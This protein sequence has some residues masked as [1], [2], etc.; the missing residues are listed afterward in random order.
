MYIDRRKIS[1]N[2]ELLI[3][4]CLDDEESLLQS[5]SLLQ[6]ELR[7]ELSSVTNRQRRLEFL[8]EHI[9]LKE[10]LGKEKRLLHEDSG[11]PYLDD[12]R[13]KISVSHSSHGEVVVAL[14]IGVA[15][16]LGIDIERKRAT[17]VRVMHKFL[18]EKEQRQIEQI[19]AERRLDALALYWCAKETIFKVMPKPLPNFADEMLVEPFEICAKGRM[20]VWGD[21]M[22]ENRKLILEYELTEEFAMTYSVIKI[23]ENEN[24]RYARG[25][26]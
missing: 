10:Y 9:L 23:E 25:R 8:V 3:G 14:I 6:D 7:S 2:V 16:S 19:S 4:R 22:G 26:P 1:E 20:T 21:T 13:L 24:K 12:N 18:S 5:F 15:T 11:K 17:L